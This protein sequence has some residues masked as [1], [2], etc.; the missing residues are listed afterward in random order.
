MIVRV[1]IKKFKIILLLVLVFALL[2]TGCDK[3]ENNAIENNEI[4]NENVITS[5]DSFQLDEIVIDSE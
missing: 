5:S 4:E 2:F 1:F 3:E